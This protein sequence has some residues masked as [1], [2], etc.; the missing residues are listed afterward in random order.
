MHVNIIARSFDERDG[1]GRF[2][3]RLAKALKT[4]DTHPTVMCMYVH[5]APKLGFW[6]G[7]TLTVSPPFDFLSLPTKHHWAYTMTEGTQLPEGWKEYIHN[8]KIQH[9]VTPSDYCTKTFRDGTKLPTYTIK[10]GVDPD[11]FN[12]GLRR[13]P[14]V[15]DRPYTFLALGDRGSRKGWIEVWQA[16]FALLDEGCNIRL[17]LKSR[18]M[19][20]SLIDTISKGKVH[21]SISFFNEDVED[22]QWVYRQADCAVIPSRS[23]GWGMPHREVAA[24]GIPLITTAYSGLDDETDEWG[25]VAH[26]GKLVPIPSNFPNTRGDWRIPNVGSIVGLMRWACQNRREAYDFGTKASKWMHK[27]RTWDQTADNLIQLMKENDVWL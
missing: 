7:V 8:A 3:H 21:P 10:G 22:M 25:L 4:H 9:I 15:S 26:F 24:M 16:F 19:G 12:T 23:E 20:N 5:Q 14:A 2:A 1:Y 18:S 13:L 17:I 6:E 11:E 27:N